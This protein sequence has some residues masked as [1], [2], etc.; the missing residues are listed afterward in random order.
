MTPGM[1]GN[2]ESSIKTN[3]YG[4][5]EGEYELND[6]L[7]DVNEKN[8]DDVV[9]ENIQY[10]LQREKKW[11]KDRFEVHFPAGSMQEIRDE[12]NR[13]SGFYQYDYTVWHGMEE[14][15]AGT[16]YGSISGGQ[17]LDMTVELYKRK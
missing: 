13:E 8:I 11:S 1:K 10:V 9:K 15:G 7:E 14:V 2:Q 16:A 17:M 12:T 4:E 3:F 5:P 6:I